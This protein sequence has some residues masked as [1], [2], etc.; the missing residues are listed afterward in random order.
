MEVLKGCVILDS[1]N[2]LR[3]LT[4][5]KRLGVP[6]RLKELSVQSLSAA[7]E[8][9]DGTTTISIPASPDLGR[10]I[11]DFAADIR[12]SPRYESLPFEVVPH[13]IPDRL[14]FERR[15][16]ATKVLATVTLTERGGAPRVAILTDDTSELFL[17]G[18]V[19]AATS[20]EP[21]RRVDSQNAGLI[22]PTQGS[23]G[24]GARTGF[25]KQLFLLFLASILGLVNK[26]N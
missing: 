9:S 13:D 7:H 18:T 23:A 3:Q 12:A 8:L 24:G 26:K 5:S 10:D 17:R 14:A 22:F 16:G 1:A 19:R 2:W 4:P 11:F 25:F 20:R 21:H 6:P 15:A